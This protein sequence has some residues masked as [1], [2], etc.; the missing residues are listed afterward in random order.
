MSVKEAFTK[1]ADKNSDERWLI[2]EWDNKANDLVLVAAEATD[3]NEMTSKFAADKIYFC[4]FKVY[5]LDERDACVSKRDKLIA[6]TWLGGSVSPLRRNAP[7]QSKQLRDSIFTGIVS[8]IQ[9]DDL[10]FFTPEAI[11]AKLVGIG[12]AHKP[13]RYD[14]GGEIS[15]PLTFY[16]HK[17]V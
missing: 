9:S 5:G 6:L 1:L 14:F 8:E 3:Y 12:G 10:Q 15:V 17:S 16:E 13:S 4:V 11:T 2:A 7:L